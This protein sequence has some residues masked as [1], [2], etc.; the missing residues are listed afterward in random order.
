MCLR[1]HKFH[2]LL[3]AEEVHEITQVLH[4]QACLLT[5]VEEKWLILADS[6]A[7]A[8]QKHFVVYIVYIWCST[9]YSPRFS[10]YPWYVLQYILSCSYIIFWN[11]LIYFQLFTRISV[12]LRCFMICFIFPLLLI[13]IFFLHY[14]LFYFMYYGFFSLLHEIYYD[15]FWS[16]ILFSWRWNTF[17]F[18]WSDT[19]YNSNNSINIS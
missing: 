12:P 16:R 9:I 13:I 11:S 17:L 10:Y 5:P 3:I 2:L 14:F 4:F 15:I 7:L 6:S 1:F 8:H 19:V 18:K